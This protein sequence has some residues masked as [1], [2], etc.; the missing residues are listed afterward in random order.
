[1]YQD[2]VSNLA[3]KCGVPKKGRKKK[4]L[5]SQVLSLVQ[6]ANNNAPVERHVVPRAALTVMN[7][8]QRE[9]SALSGE[10]KDLGVLREVAKFITAHQDTHKAHE[11]SVNTD[12]L[13]VGHPKSLKNLS[14]TSEIVRERYAQWL[15]SDSSIHTSIKPLVAAAHSLEPGSLERQHAFTRLSVAKSANIPAFFKIDSVPALVAAFSFSGGNSSAARRARVALQWRDRKGRWV[16]MGRGANFRFRMPN[17]NVA[18]ASGVY[19]GV[20]IPQA[21]ENPRPAGLIQV[22][23]DANLPDGIYAVQ[24]GNTETFSAR[25]PTEALEKAGIEP[26]IVTRQS[27]LGVPSQADILATRQDAPTG[28]TKKD[29]ETFTSDDDYTVKYGDGEYTLWRQKEDGSLGDKVGDAANW[30]G[31]NDLATADQASYDEAKGQGTAAGDDEQVKARL[32]NRSKY[33][34]EFDRLEEIANSGVDEKGNKLPEGWKGVVKPGALMPVERRAIG[35]PRA[36]GEEGLPYLEYERTYADDNGNPVVA[37]ASYTNDGKLYANGKPYESWDAAEADIPNWIKAEEEA[38]GRTLQPAAPS[39][40]PA[41]PSAARTLIPEGVEKSG[42]L[43]NG[44]EYSVEDVR[45]RVQVFPGRFGE[46]NGVRVTLDGNTYENRKRIKQLGFKWNN[47]D[48]VWIKNFVESDLLGKDRNAKRIKAELDGIGGGVMPR[49]ERDNEEVRNYL[50]EAL[51]SIT[52]LSR[53][54]DSPAVTDAK[55]ILWEAM[56]K[57]RKAEPNDRKLAQDDLKT[58]ISALDAEDFP[59]GERAN[60]AKAI[61]MQGIDLIDASERERGVVP[62]EAPEAPKG[63]NEVVAKTPSD[64]T[65]TSPKLFEEFDTPEGAF[66]LRTVDYEPEGRIDEE[67]TDFTDDPERLATKYALPEL[68]AAL[69]QALIGDKDNSVIAQIVDSSIG[70]DDESLDL[71]EVDDV[72]DTPAPQAGRANGTGAGQLEFN[73]GSEFVPAEALYNAVF[74]AGGDPNRV[75]ANAYDAVNGN[76]NNLNK[77]HDAAG[78]VPDAEDAQLIDDIFQE[79]RQIKDVSTPEEL[80]QKG[81]SPIDGAEEEEAP[82]PGELLH[83]IPVNFDNPDYYDIDTNPYPPMREEPDEFGFTDDPAY[84]ARNFA[85]ADLLEQFETAITDGSGS[86]YLIY[87]SDV[88][89]N[90][91]MYEVPAEAIRDALQLQGVNTNDVLERI[92]AE[93][94]DFENEP[95]E[96][97][98]EEPAPAPTPEE[99]EPSF[100][101]IPFDGSINILKDWYDR[102][103]LVDADF[104]AYLPD[105]GSIVFKDAWDT[106]YVARAD[107]TIVEANTTEEW[108]TDPRGAG[109]AGWKLFTS[110]QRRSLA[111]KIIGREEAAP[112]P[113]P[114]A[115]TPAIPYP[116]PREAGYSPNNTTIVAGGTIVGKGSRVKATKDGKL[117]T[118][119]AIQNDPEYLRIKFDD[120]TT[121]VRAA[122]K[123]RAIS[124]ADGVAPTVAE[125]PVAEDNVR[126]RLEAP[127][128]PAPRVGRSGETQGV[129]DESNRP[130]F[131]NGLT[132]EDAKQADYAA[133]GDRDAEIAKAARER[134]TRKAFEDKLKEYLLIDNTAENRDLKAAANNDL[135]KMLGDVYGAREGISFGGEFYT[136]DPTRITITATNAVTPWKTA[137]AEDIQSG[138]FNYEVELTMNIR[139]VSGNAI[140]NSLRTITQDVKLDDNENIKSSKVYV[141]NNF[142]ALNAKGKKKGFATAFNR[143]AE[144]WYIAND[145]DEVHVYAAGG[146]QYQGGFVWALNGFDWDPAFDSPNAPMSSFKRAVKNKQEEEQ[147]A[148]IQRKLDASKKPGGGYDLAKAPTPLEYALVGWY[149]GAED[150]LGKR[151]MT[152]LSWHGVKRLNPGAREQRQAANYTQIKNAERR[153]V[154]NQNLPNVSPEFQ[155][156]VATD[157]FKSDKDIA[158]YVDEIRDVLRNNRSLAFLAPDAKSALGRYV[159]N[160]IMAGSSER[161]L[162]LEDAFRLRTA[163]NAEYRAD[164]QYTDPLNVAEILSTLSIDDFESQSEALTS[165]G[166]SA[167]RLSMDES[168]VNMTFEVTHKP[169]GQVFYVKNEEFAARFSDVAGGITELEATTILNAAGVVGLHNVLVGKNEKNLIVMS[170]AGSG[171]PLAGEPVNGWSLSRR[172]IVDA[173][174]R[175][176]TIPTDNLLDY[177]AAP[178]DVIRMSL[179]DMLGNNQDRHNGNWMAAYNK[180][181]GK[182]RLFPIDNTVGVIPK[183]SSTNVEEFLDMGGFMEADVYS[184]VMPQLIDRIGSNDVFRMYE[185]EIKNITT[186]LDNPLYKPKGFEMDAIIAK[187]GTYDAFKDAITERLNRLITPGNG[188]YDSLKGALRLGYWG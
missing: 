188:E 98:A 156:V 97:V 160:Q 161:Q 109:Q 100:D 151:V 143:Y 27:V 50:Q 54:D 63:D 91:G 75:I 5:S 34:E 43:P 170:R 126:R 178:E 71:E 180:V 114:A 166:F 124:N 95:E 13:P 22:S 122:A 139:D 159:S 41:A 23:G 125:A 102:D 69:T 183:D 173:N 16:E 52:L 152:Q 44:V 86:V 74:L 157:D 104:I 4:S 48:K 12:L 35:A 83:N 45:Q 85:E 130:A 25:I 42:T 181:T 136:I 186:N 165:A 40:T 158:P 172:G 19:V 17:G 18:S 70:E 61:A 174:G 182:V 121:A 128:V 137:S 76:R 57:L 179:F 145:I 105:D 155:G 24:P 64:V 164:Y 65:P 146:G 81:A 77:L 96:V 149:P 78:G 150:W 187:W 62:Q 1:M 60:K 119:V 51:N 72:I 59:K 79:I 66:R 111:D 82:L 33:N 14:A 58:F 73:K 185:N 153:V 47:Q 93:S 113:A 88:P 138:K 103:M 9:L 6:E 135:I 168:G 94:I 15:A 184:I 134:V 162:P 175:K 117:G 108:L 38:R 2:I 30:A 123:V 107:Q 20:N 129:N 115:P 116:G 171:I 118:V 110:D 132:N 49:Y 3:N 131:L 31:I 80:E 39:E 90:E 167:R 21:G 147:V 84:I 32:E 141:K 55:A 112:T 101:Q 8:A 89:L 177:L 10:S 37:N 46:T 163:L 133:W 28:W 176:V 26:G 142:L 127:G 29:D 56:E 92:R 169:S 120:G 7:R 36:F 68:T 154:G 148:A 144:N 11:Y 87:N 99:S 106:L 53:E 140:G 67:S